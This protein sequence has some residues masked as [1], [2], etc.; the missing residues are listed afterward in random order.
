MIERGK[1]LKKTTKLITLLIL[2][3]I[4][5]NGLTLKGQAY[6]LMSDSDFITSYGYTYEITSTIFVF[7][8]DEMGGLTWIHSEVKLPAPYAGAQGRLFTREGV[9]VGASAWRYIDS[10]GTTIGVT[11][12]V[13][14]GIYYSRG[15]V[16]IYNGKQ[17]I[18]YDAPQSPYGIRGAN[19]QV[20]KNEN[21]NSYGSALCS[22][23]DNEPDLIYAQGENGKI[24]Y[25]R[26]SDLNQGK[27]DS[28]ED[29]LAGLNNM[30]TGITIPVYE[31]DGITIIDSFKLTME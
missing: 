3:I 15:L 1:G 30:Q 7:N 25:V 28:L 8:N 26:K 21:G 13:P 11:K 10:Y 31:A 4:I 17:Y 29:A 2:V 6:S 22:I 16:D 5:S 20:L 23:N 24:G 9:L 18:T 27:A 19:L 14:D 12:E